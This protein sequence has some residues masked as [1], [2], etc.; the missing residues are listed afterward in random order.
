M[1][2]LTMKTNTLELTGDRVVLTEGNSIATGKMLIVYLDTGRMLLLGEEK[3]ERVKVLIKPKES[4]AT[5][6]PEN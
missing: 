1:V 4:T 5:S 2:Y 3:K 6:T